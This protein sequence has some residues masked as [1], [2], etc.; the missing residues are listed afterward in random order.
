MFAGVKVRGPAGTR[1][2]HLV[3][4][5]ISTFSRFNFVPREVRE[6]NSTQKLIDLQNFKFKYVYSIF[7][8]L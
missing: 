6:T 8:M 2:E 4:L 7:S 1:M 5:Y 3:F